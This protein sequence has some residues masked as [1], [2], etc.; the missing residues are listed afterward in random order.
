VPLALLLWPRRD[1]PGVGPLTVLM[2]GVAL[3]SL[4]YAFSLTQVSL[5]AQLFWINMS[6]LGI[7]LVPAS[8]LAFALEY[9]GQGVWLTRRRLA[10]LAIEPL[11]ALALALTNDLHLLFRT[12][13]RL[14]DVGTYLVLESAFGPA[15]WLHTVYSRQVA[16]EPVD[17]QVQPHGHSVEI[18]RVQPAPALV[19]QV[20]HRPEFA[21]RPRRLG[22]LGGDAGA[23]M[24]ARLREMPEHEE[25]LLPQLLDQPVDDRVGGHA[26]GALVVAVFHQRDRGAGGPKQ[27]VLLR[28]RN[29]QLGNGICHRQIV[30]SAPA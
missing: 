19:K 25:Q 17:V 3:W 28:D 2:L 15:F 1:A 13:V 27:M 26:V 21:L 10:L 29:R 24:D 16:L 20:V 4:A 23:W 7:G 30:A 12:E 11:L 18:R 9:I 14:L 22:G 5:S 8:W 6:Y